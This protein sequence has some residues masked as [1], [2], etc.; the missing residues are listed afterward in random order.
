MVRRLSVGVIVLG[1][2]TALI[3]FA[4]RVFSTNQYPYPSEAY[5]LND[6]A[7]MYSATTENYLIGDA[8]NLYETTK[9]IPNVGGAQIVFATFIVE[10]QADVSNYN[11]TTIFREWK[12]GKNNMG[13]LALFFFDQLNENEI[14]NFELIEFQIE[15]SDKMMIYY[16]VITQLDIYN[17]TLNTHL[18]KGTPTYPGDLALE[19]GT[20]SFMNELINVAYANIYGLNDEVYPQAEFD[21]DFEQYWW[22]DSSPHQYHADQPLDLFAY[23]FSGYGSIADRIIFGSLSVLTLLATGG[24]GIYKGGGGWSAGGGLFRR[25]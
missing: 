17:R 9:N 12:V 2:F 8:E 16:P 20:A 4:I 15:A 21:P 3:I 25:R 11:K 7:E 22:D 5:Y 13:L 24:A 6:Y 14:D 10:D 18:P 1:L 19:L 23:F